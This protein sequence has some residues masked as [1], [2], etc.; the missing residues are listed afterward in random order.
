V[1]KL[2]VVLVL[3]LLAACSEDLTLPPKV[4]GIVPPAP[5]NFTVTTSDVIVY[6]LNWTISD[7]TV[8]KFYRLYAVVPNALPELVDTTLATSV[9]VN[10]NFP[11]PGLFFAV[12][13]VSTDNIESALVFGFP[14]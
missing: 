9:Q 7:P 1:K 11:T 2:L 8:I 3:L 10:T 13:S 14:E 6:D 12:S 5:G 4:D